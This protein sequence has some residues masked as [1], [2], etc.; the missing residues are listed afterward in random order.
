MT[1]EAPVLLRFPGE[2]TIANL[3]RFRKEYHKTLIPGTNTVLDLS[4]VTSLNSCF[5]G[6]IVN[7]K[8]HMGEE[9]DLSAINAPQGCQNLIDICKLQHLISFS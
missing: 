5:I 1:I 3:I 2:V 9:A 4:D 7:L 6:V 8:R